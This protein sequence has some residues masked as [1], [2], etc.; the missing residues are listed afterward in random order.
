MMSFS[1]CRLT[2]LIAVALAACQPESPP[3]FYG[4]LYFEAG[5]YLG[6]FSLSTGNAVP[7]TNLGDQRIRR[8]ST[9]EHG[10]LLLTIVN[11]VDERARY[12][13][14]R[15]ELDTVHETPLLEGQAG[16]YLETPATI[17]YYRGYELISARRDA[18]RDPGHVVHRFAYREP[19]HLVPVGAFGVLFGTNRDVIR[20]FDPA[21]GE[22][23]VLEALSSACELRDAVWLADRE[24]LA[25]R[26]PGVEDSAPAIVLA[27][28][29]GRVTGELALPAG[30]RFRPV[31][32]LADQ[33]ALVLNET[34]RR[35]LSRH[36][37]YPVWTYGLDSGRLQRLAGNQ[38]LGESAVYRRGR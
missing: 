22:T 30:R 26:E 19:P 27:S 25:C 15:F 33:G 38:H 11:Y 28:L 10:Q 13:I 6:A 3:H 14:A 34:R 1:R 31:V 24:Q 12:R 23:Q 8:V 29:D 18:L 2:V 37:E 16:Q 20:R 4:T 32:Y 36:D 9:F 17:V 35:L 21:T 7:V 5:P